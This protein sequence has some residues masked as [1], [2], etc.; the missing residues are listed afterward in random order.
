MRV[1]LLGVLEVRDADDRDIAIPSGKQQA[2]LALL[3]LN[4]GRVVPAEQVVDALWGEN[5]PPRVRNG[6]QALA[7]KLRA[8]LGA[9]DLVVM[10]GGGYVLEVPPDA[11]DIHRYET[12]VATARAVATDDPERAIALYGESD[13]LWRGDPLVDFAYEEFAQPAIARL[14]EL[15]LAVIEERVELEVALGHVDDSVIELEALVAAHP[16]RERLRGQLMVAL[17]RAGRQ[18]DALRVF[19]EGRDVLVEELG[20][21]PGP[22]LRRLEAA[23]L[24]QDPD[25]DGPVPGPVR[26]S[27]LAPRHGTLPASLSRLIGRDDEL[28]ELAR[29]AAESRFVTLVGPG[30]VGKTRLALEVGR[31]VSN[32]LAD[33]GFLVELA[34]VGDPAAVGP[35]IASALDLP[36]AARL[37]ELIDDRELVIVLDN[38]EHVIDAAAALAEDLLRRCPRLR[39]IATSREAL[40]VSGETVW[41]VSPLSRADAEELF[42][43]RAEA[44]G[45]SLDLSG[46]AASLIADICV[47]LDGLPLAIELAAAR[48]RALPLQQ[49]A[50]RLNDRFRL[51]TGGSRT[52]LPRQQTLHAVVDWSYDLL[53]DAEQRIFERLSVFPGGCDLATAEAVCADDELS[54]DD[55]ADLLQTLVDKSL[56]VARRSRDGIRY[57]QLQT[58][59]QYGQEK[60]TAR[61]DAQR[62]RDAMAAHFAVRCAQGK[63]A[64]SGPSQ[65]PWLLMMNE[66][67]DNVRASLEWAIAN[68]DAET[69]MVIAGGASWMHWLAG[70]QSEGMRWLD[71][72]FACKGSPTEQTRALALTAGGMFRFIRG[73]IPSADVDFQEAREV[74]L[75]HDDR[76]GLVFT[77]SFY[78][79]AARM[80]GRSGEA[81]TRR[82]ETLELYREAPDDPFIVG[83][84]AF[85]HAILALIDNDL[86]VAERHYRIA[87]DAFRAGGRPFMLSVTLGFLADFDER[88]A[89]YHDAVEALEE[90][91]ELAET[92]GM[93]GYLGSLY[94]RLAWSLLEEGDITRAELMIERALE[95]GWRLRSAH[96]LFPAHAGSALLH[97]LHGRNEDAVA[98]ASEALRIHEVEGPSGF[99][100]R[101]DPD[102]EIASVLAVCS[103][104]L[105]VIALESGELDRGAD[106]LQ[107][108][109]TLRQDVG[110]PEPKFQM[111]DLEAARRVLLSA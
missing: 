28:R 79:E 85:S 65:G 111:A 58:L 60:L 84:R 90:A 2:L 66:E 22:Q 32:A 7:S 6:L 23:I 16:L 54:R 36:D 67:Q 75:R 92:F 24:A 96:I 59:A 19:Q 39:L 20:L 98:A 17:Y 72:A 52:A 101:I 26:G 106:L 99:R 42:I 21:E 27:V 107:R 81:R 88:N 3:A 91:V 74:F 40:R 18:A 8:A 105:A 14:S 13:A 108:A 43:A 15:R 41:P 4:A 1:G 78:A 73:D 110:A 64:Y 34:T 55:I 51:L 5:P 97:R 93:R 62:V 9:A 50:A 57:S 102:F 82:L 29:L 104:I 37:A 33:G 86:A 76:D 95:A 70:T 35:A 69:A 83:A 109:D 61:G 38:C 31:A 63:E 12:L 94:S 10:R 71:E 77:L 25:L 45:A 30:G 103:T 80:S 47:R 49:I 89:R 11:T 46:E 100:N 48:S 44:A 68:D 87:A 53:F 56:V